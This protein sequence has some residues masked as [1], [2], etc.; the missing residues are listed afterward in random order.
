MFS[1]KDHELVD[2][3]DVA[4]PCTNEIIISLAKGEE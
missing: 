4:I 3:G 1:V 2:L